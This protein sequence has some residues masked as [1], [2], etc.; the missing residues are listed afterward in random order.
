MGRTQALNQHL[1][2]LRTVAQLPRCPTN[3]LPC[4]RTLQGPA[5]STASYLNIPAIVEAIQKTGAD[6]VHPGYGG[7]GPLI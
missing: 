5:P 2:C 4:R 6:A 1:S 7:R 3:R